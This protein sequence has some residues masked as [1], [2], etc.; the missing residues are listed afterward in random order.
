MQRRINEGI[1]NNIFSI[2]AS[3]ATGCRLYNLPRPCRKTLL[4]TI[5][6][7]YV[8][9]IARLMEQVDGVTAHTAPLLARRVETDQLETTLNDLRNRAIGAGLKVN[10]YGDL[11]S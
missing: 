7:V 1:T 10:P 5:E 9:R 4:K 11:V 3:V 6:L 8:H 2:S